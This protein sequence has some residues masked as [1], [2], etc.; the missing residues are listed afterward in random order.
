MDLLDIAHQ[1]RWEAN[2]LGVFLPNR[3]ISQRILDAI[4]WKSILF[5]FN[6]TC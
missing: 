5:I 3:L 2:P 1:I 6:L 4:V